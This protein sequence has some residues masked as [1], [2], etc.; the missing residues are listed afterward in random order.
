MNSESGSSTNSATNAAK[1]SRKNESHK[2]HS[3]STP[4]SITFIRRPEWV[5]PWKEIGSCST[6]SK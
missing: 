6:C 5:P 3:A 2:P 4:V 1:C